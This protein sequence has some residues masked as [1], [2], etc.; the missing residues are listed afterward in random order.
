MRYTLVHGFCFFKLF[1][2]GCIGLN[3]SLCA[4]IVKTHNLCFQE[5]EALEAVFTK[6]LCPNLISGHAK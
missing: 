2:M 5:C 1:R 6:D 4:G 3:S